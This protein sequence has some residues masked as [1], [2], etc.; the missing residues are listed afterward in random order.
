MFGSNLATSSLRKASADLQ[1]RGDQQEGNVAILR[2]EKWATNIPAAFM[3]AAASAIWLISDRPALAVDPVCDDPTAKNWT[4]PI[5]NPEPAERQAIMDLI[6]RYY[7]ALDEKNAAAIAEMFTR[8]ANYQ[9]CSGGGGLKRD[10][11]KGPDEVATYFKNL[12]SNLDHAESRV[13]HFESNT[14]LNI[15]DPNAPGTVE[16]K[17]AMLAVIQ[18]ADNEVPTLDYAAVLRAVFVKENGAWKFDMLTLI[19]DE[20]KVMVRAR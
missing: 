18:R 10:R 16:A 9:V 4:Y 11:R 1:S 6:H 7:W 12:F 20:P 19:T 17:S 5:T 15:V 13:R 3:L 2:K 8:D 14:L